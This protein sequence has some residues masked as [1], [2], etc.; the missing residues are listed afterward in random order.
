[1][2]PSATSRAT[3][4]RSSHSSAEAEAAGSGPGRV[5]R[6]RPH[7]LPARGSPVGAGLRRRTT[8]SA[9]EKVAAATQRCAAVVGFVEEDGD[10]YNAA[11]VCA[12]GRG[13]RDRAQA[14]A[15]QLRRVRRAA[16]LR[17]RR[18][19]R[20]SCSRSP[21]VRV[22][23]DHLRGRLEP[24]RPDRQ[25]RRGRCRAGRDGERLALPGRDSRPAGAHARDAGGR[26]LRALLAM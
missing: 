21:G 23:R 16:L 15:P 25:A 1:M 18:R 12:G 9:L 24:G 3:P 26:R 20:T 19:D 22:G 7:R 10:L 13:A 11:A 8:C 4:R 17:S 2:S 14:A 5:P 6:A